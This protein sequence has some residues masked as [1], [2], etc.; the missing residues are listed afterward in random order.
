[1]K[2]PII[3]QKGIT[4][5]ALVITIIVLLILAGISIATLTGQNG[6]LSKASTATEE[7]KKAEYEEVIKLIGNG[8]RPEKVLEN[9]SAEEFMNRYQKELEK[10]TENG[11]RLEDAKIERRDT[12]T[13]WVTTKE[14]WLYE[15]T[16]NEVKLKGKKGENP[17]PDLE[18][19]DITFILEP[20]GYTNQ[21]VTV[22]IQLNKDIEGFTLQ[23]S[24]DGSKWDNYTTGEK[25]LYTENGTIHARLINALEEEGGTASEP[26]DKIDKEAPNDAT[27][28]FSSTT[29]DTETP[30]TA[31]VSQT[32]KGNSGVDFTKCK[33]KYSTQSGTIGTTPS[34]YTGT[35][36]KNEQ[37]ITLSAT[38]PG[39]YYLHILTI[40]RAGNPKETI[41]GS[42]TV[43]KAQPK[44]GVIVTGENQEYTKNGTAIIPVGF[45][46]VPGC[47][48][49]DKGLVISDVANDTGNTGNQFVWIPVTDGSKYVR[50]TS[51]QNTTYSSQAYDDTG[52]LPNGVTNEKDTVVKAKGFYIARYETGTGLVSK[53]GVKVWTYIS[54]TD[55]KAQGKNFIN[56]NYVKSALVSG[57]Q[58]D[59]TMSFVNGKTDGNQQTYNVTVVNGNRHRQ[60]EKVSGFNE[61][62]RVCNIYDLEGNCYENI[63][64]KAD[65]RPVRRGG[66]WANDPACKRDTFPD[67]GTNVNAFRMVLYVM[68][69]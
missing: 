40:D 27:V 43:K 2:K 1:M 66:Y 55:A 54:Q 19:A 15:I 38:T 48:D 60:E 11:R 59:V 22:E 46:I 4:L 8:L 64:E 24:R 52:Y 5:I 28:R 10:E 44:A 36:S 61:A 56:N 32:D 67:A 37:T 45:A 9:L 50:N 57:I 39:T 41:R 25:I 26:I 18:D 69:N 33:W 63:A 62:D 13:I 42:I 3:K 17:P 68:K 29:T 47:E 16:E 6:I 12:E 35:F 53:K 34:S 23:Y 58:W 21:N 7:N 51:Y 30:I 20:E 49:V 65:G 31:T 14:G